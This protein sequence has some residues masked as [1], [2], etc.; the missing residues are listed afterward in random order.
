MKIKEMISKIE[1]LKVRSAWDKGV[2][3]YA[4]ELLEELENIENTDNITEKILLNGATNWSE[5]SWSGCSLIYNDDICERLCT[6]SEKKR[7]KKRTIKTK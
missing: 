2:K 4:I 7:T 1:G 6:E 3:V 5:Y